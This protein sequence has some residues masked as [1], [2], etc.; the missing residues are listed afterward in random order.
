MPV[1]SNDQRHKLNR[2][3]VAD[4][5]IVLIEFQEDGRS[6]VHRAAINTEDVTWRG[7]VYTRAAISVEM[8]ET[9]DGETRAQLAMSNVDRLISR[10]LNGAT[11]RIN[12]RIILIDFAAPDT[13]IIDTKNLL[14][15]P[16]ASG[17]SET[18]TG[19]L[20]PRASLLEP[21]PFKMTTREDFPGLWL[22]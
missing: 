16:S 12:V 8:P 7:N 6:L 17:N 19:Q 1:P 14:V 3:P 13:P 10:A 20:G 5:H 9:R 11:Q 4:P 18:V 22:T 2:D 21:I 15:M